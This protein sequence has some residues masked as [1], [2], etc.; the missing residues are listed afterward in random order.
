VW[1]KYQNLGREINRGYY[2]R[3]G[4]NGKDEMTIECNIMVDNTGVRE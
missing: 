1:G 2:D 3:K 4:R